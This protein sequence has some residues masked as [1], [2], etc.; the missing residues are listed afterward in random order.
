MLAACDCC[1][2][3][4]AL[5]RDVEWHAH[6]GRAERPGPVD[7]GAPPPGLDRRTREVEVGES[8]NEEKL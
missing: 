4:S 5:G 1:P 8:G 2:R 7:A 6:A 3:R